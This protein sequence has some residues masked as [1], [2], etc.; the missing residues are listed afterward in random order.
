MA[1]LENELEDLCIPGIVVGN[2]SSLLAKDQFVL[3]QFRFFASRFISS[4][5][6]TLLNCF[7]K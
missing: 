2:S 3:L 6:G 4:L 7:D 5:S 1:V